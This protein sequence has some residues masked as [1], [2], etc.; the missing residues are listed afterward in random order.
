ML[1][2]GEKEG[3]VC[4]FG[5]EFFRNLFLPAAAGGAGEVFARVYAIACRDF[6]MWNAAVCHL[7]G[8]L[9]TEAKR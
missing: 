6:S 3:T 5:G 7:A 8:M 1:L 2:Q 4:D 9:I